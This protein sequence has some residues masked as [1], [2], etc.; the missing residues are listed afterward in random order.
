LDRD[1]AGNVG[2]SSIVVT[3][4]TA[5]LS[6]GIYDPSD[7]KRTKDENLTI[8]GIADKDTNVT[9]NGNLV[10]LGGTGTQFQYIIRLKEGEN[11]I[12]IRAVD[13]EGNVNQKVL[14]VYLDTIPPS[15]AITSPA[16]GAVTNQDSIVVT[17][18]T[19]PGTTV[20]VNGQVVDNIGG[21]FSKEVPLTASQNKITID[22][23]D[24]VGNAVTKEIHVNKKTIPPDLNIQSPK[25][26]QVLNAQAMGKVEVR[27]KTDPNAK[28]YVNGE[29]A[30]M[31]GIS[32]QSNVYL[33]E[34]NNTI[35]VAAYDEAG[36]INTVTLHVTYDSQ[37]NAEILTPV[38]EL[39]TSADFVMATG[40]VEP[41][42]T[43]RI[44]NVNVPVT[45]A[46]GFSQSVK[47]DKG[48]DSLS[49]V[50]TDKAG[51]SLAV[52]RYVNRGTG[53]NKP[54]Q[55]A[56]TL[57]L[58]ALILIVVVVVAIVAVLAMGRRKKV[59]SMQ[60]ADDEPL[61][62]DLSSA[63]SPPPPDFGAGGVTPPSAYGDAA[64]QQGYTQEEVTLPPEEQGQAYGSD[65]EAEMTPSATE[66]P[67]ELAPVTTET[68]PETME[69]PEP[70]DEEEDMTPKRAPMP[71]D[72][73]QPTMKFKDLPGDDEV[74]EGTQKRKSEAWSK[75]E[76][77]PRDVLDEILDEEQK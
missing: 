18:I 64:P 42:A 58:V 55:D 67:L 34:G 7:N 27:G 77:K 4:H 60:I 37:V 73:P 2:T 15:L 57:N 5:I 50:M 51:N 52:T 32:F 45:P 41:G 25:D 56:M 9:I 53:G 1:K 46:G 54:S 19:D 69:E 22:A 16:D 29:K 13:P 40:F 61:P 21:A 33:A 76:D 72:A 20:K 62:P 66:L 30:G 48:R 68:Q 70:L 3:L 11:D 17:G 23:V 75:R 44:N 8:K 59:A 71:E 74:A 35:Q 10:P 12:V 6:L 14:T 39:N 31:A 63:S 26:G 49:F 28:V 38:N 65:A 36:N 47:L 43:V 24:S